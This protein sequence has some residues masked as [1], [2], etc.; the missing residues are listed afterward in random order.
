VIV[1]SE[2]LEYDPERIARFDELASC[3]A[4]MPAT[5]DV[6]GHLPA[7]ADETSTS[8]PFFE[9]YF[10]NLIEGTEFSIDEAEAIVESGEIPLER[11]EDAHDVLGTFEAGPTPRTNARGTRRVP[12]SRAARAAQRWWP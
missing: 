9:A 2:G 1:G 6:P 12:R 7:L 8:L 5:L 3:L 11:P 10:S 4:N